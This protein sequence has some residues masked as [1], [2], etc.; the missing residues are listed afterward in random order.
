M[1]ISRPCYGLP[2]V[3]GLIHPLAKSILYGPSGDT[4]DTLAKLEQRSAQA[5]EGRA[6]RP[7][8]L[9][10]EA[11]GAFDFVPFYLTGPIGFGFSYPDPGSKSL[12]PKSRSRGTVVMR[13]ELALPM[14]SPP[15]CPFIRSNFEL[16]VH[17][18]GIDG[19]ISPAR[20]YT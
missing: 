5:I 10:R 2:N 14:R 19:R 17:D 13:A 18:S 6:A 12:E 20:P 3:T 16:T 15:P 7:P 11:S 1:D 8:A 9:R 4:T